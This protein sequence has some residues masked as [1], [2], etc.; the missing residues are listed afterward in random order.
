VP[1]TVAWHAADGNPVRVA[2]RGGSL[3]LP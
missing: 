1:L 2:Y 3:V